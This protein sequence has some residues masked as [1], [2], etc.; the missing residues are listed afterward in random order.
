MVAVVIRANVKNRFRG[1]YALETYLYLIHVQWSIEIK[2]AM[3]KNTEKRLTNNNRL[4]HV[5]VHRMIG[6]FALDCKRYNKLDID[7][8]EQR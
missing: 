1:K 5:E 6:C 4:H 3:A 2:K 8:T 7:F